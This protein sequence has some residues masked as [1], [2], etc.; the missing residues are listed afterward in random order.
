M[1]SLNAQ[2][3]KRVPYYPKSLNKINIVISPSRHKYFVRNISKRTI[4]I[5][6]SNENPSCAPP[7]LLFPSCQRVGLSQSVFAASV[8]KSRQYNLRIYNRSRVSLFTTKALSFHLSRVS[9]GIPHN[10]FHFRSYDCLD[11]LFLILVYESSHYM[12]QSTMFFR[13]QK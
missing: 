8:G 4:Q 5:E 6:F 7:L 3:I 11:V 9:I 1:F 13:H 2:I 10:D 12:N